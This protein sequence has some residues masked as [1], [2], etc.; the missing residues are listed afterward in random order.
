MLKSARILVI[1]PDSEGRG[2]LREA[3]R[4]VV[5]KG[6]Y[7]NARALKPAIDQLR[8]DEKYDFAFL[9]TE[10]PPDQLLEFLG[11]LKALSSKQRPVVMLCMKPQDQNSSIVANLY[12][13]GAQGFVFEPY[14]PE[15]LLEAMNVAQEKLSDKVQAKDV[16]ITEFLLGDAM[17]LLDEVAD[18]RSEGNLG[19]GFAGK[20]LRRVAGS[21]KEAAS[22]IDATQYH[23]LLIEKF[24]KATTKKKGV[25]PPKVVKKIREAPHPGL[26]LRAIMTQRSLSKEK[27][28]SIVKIDAAELDAILSGQTSVTEES[29]RELARAMGKTSKH[30]MQLQHAFD[31]AKKEK[32][33]AAKKGQM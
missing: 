11:A 28:L 19:S 12:A 3:L 22:K 18:W 26:E 1:N 4:S 17:R 9:S 20:E 2:R 32:E 5:A 27:L 30:W 15:Q 24:S 6:A 8:G 25:E 29:A 33:E 7:A 14:S 16:R 10:F 23:N 31:Q 21:L 13:N